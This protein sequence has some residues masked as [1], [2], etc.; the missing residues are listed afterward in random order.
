[1]A[2]GSNLSELNLVEVLQKASDPQHVGS[3]LQKQAE[4]QLKSW[5][6]QG[7]YHYTLQSVY[8]DLSNALQV[9]WLAIIQFKNGVEKYWRSTRNNAISKDEKNMIRVRLFDLIAE[10]NN[11][12][13]IQNA[14]ATARIARLDFPAEWPNVFE[15]LENMLNNEN[16]WKDEVKIYNL[17]LMSNQI[18]KILATARIGRCRPA[19]QSKV[20]LVFPLLV[21]VYVESFR[22]WTEATIVDDESLSHIQ[23]SYLALKVLRRVVIEGYDFPHRDKAVVEFMQMIVSHFEMLTSNYDSLRKFNYI[24]K[25]VKCYGKL[26]YYMILASPAN[27][28]LLPC[29]SNALMAIT[30]ILFD[31]ANDVY[32]ENAEITGDFWEQVA[33]RGFLILKK[34]VNFLQKKGTVTIKARNDKNEVQLAIQKISTEFF[35]EGLV[36]KLVDV[37][38]Q[39]YLKLRPAE[40]ENWDIDPEEWINEQLV[41]SYEYQIRPCAENF[42]QDLVNGFR[43][44]LVPYLLRKIE[45]EGSPQDDTIE[46]FLQKDSVFAAFQLSAAATSEMVDFDSIL[47]QVFL[48]Q[49]NAA[50]ESAYQAKIIKRRVCLVINEWGTVRCST[51]S[52]QYCYQLLRKLLGEETDKVVQ[53]TAIE[54]LRTLI[55]DWN[56]DKKSFQPYLDDFAGLLLRKILPSVSLTETRLFV[57]KTLSDMIVQTKPFF[58]REL[59]FE[60]LQIVPK[61]WDLS[62]S[63]PSESILANAL[64]R[65]L[66]HSIDSLGKFSGT[67]WDITLPIVGIAC[68]PSTSQYS[69]L[70]EDGFDLWLALLQNCELE[71]NELDP[72]FYAL[73]SSLQYGVQ[74]QTEILPTLLE[75]VKSYSL[76]CSPK[77]FLSHPEFRFI[78]GHLARFI[79]KLR[80]DSLEILLSIADILTLVNEQNS[81]GQ[82]LEFF[83]SCGLLDAFMGG[84]FREESL[85]SF[86]NAQLLQ[87]ISRIAFITPLSVTNFIADYHSRQPTSRENSQLP[88]I[89]RKSISSD[90]PLDE[91]LNKFIT[92]WILALNEV[93]DPR[94]KKAHILGLSSLLKTGLGAVLSN[95]Q[96]IASIWVTAL[97]EVNETTEG[98]CEKYHLSEDLSAENDENY[99]PSC[100]QLRLH[101]LIKAQDP[102]HNISLKRFIKSILD[103]LQQELGTDFESLLASVHPTTIENLQQFLNMGP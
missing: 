44:L 86:Q 75:I 84:L 69:L 61:L 64:L 30:R 68:D 11:Q 21:R 4:Q 62:M 25:F 16:I 72:R 41:A 95:F 87:S 20:P 37:L 98:D 65:L 67:T 76:L 51:Q 50:Y 26:F 81:E 29:A 27:F 3:D 92:I 53:L 12:L 60:I 23:V 58:S 13:C 48:P 83:F 22:I 40:L 66:K 78:L 57:F 7:G 71:A 94:W 101:R 88:A 99:I 52:K 14:Q 96:N 32:N 35:N 55:D 103:L 90:M 79:L 15:T 97:E 8:L 1:M 59:L 42:F 46:S 91:V 77:A 85:S 19:M 10:R 43:E 47:V 24:E 73:V 36:T 2:N 38:M 31:R 33:I 70:Y 49:A 28:L 54:A 93:Y 18:I 5:E 80:D 9:R 74:H 34:I 39:W 82:L 63:D 45:N 56:F 100:E 6:V 17:L 102:V 89:D